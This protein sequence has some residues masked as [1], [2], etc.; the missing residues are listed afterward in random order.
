MK[1]RLEFDFVTPTLNGKNGLIREHF[2]AKKKR[3]TAIKWAIISEKP[4]KHKGKVIITY[5]RASVVAPDWDNLCA[6]FKHWGDG[7][8]SSGVIKDDKPSI[9]V[10]FKPR[11]EKAKNN[12][13][14]YTIIEIEDVE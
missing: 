2:H 11:W 1:Q 6:S 4:N 13:S 5:T 3:Q 10:E 8:V 12:K 9:I 7:L 14:V